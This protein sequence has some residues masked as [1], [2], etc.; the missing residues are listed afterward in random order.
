MV[1]LTLNTIKLIE[2]YFSPDEKDLIISF[3]SEEC[4]DNLPFHDNCGPIDMER[5]RFAAIKVS[6][7]ELSKLESAVELAKVDWRDLLVHAE[8][9]D[10][11]KAHI[12]WAS[13]K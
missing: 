9:A 3:L 8:F 5:I 11:T 4:G 7:G 12:I 2:K 1:D 10:D 6:N 13:K